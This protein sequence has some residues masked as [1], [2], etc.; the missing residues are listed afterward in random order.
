[1]PNRREGVFD[2]V[3]GSDAFPML[4]RKVIESQEDVALS[5][6]FGDGLVV[7]HT[8]CRDEIVECSVSVDTGFSPPDVVQLSL[9]KLGHRVQHVARFVEPEEQSKQPVAT[10]DQ[11][12]LATILPKE[13]LPFK[14]FAGTTGHGKAWDF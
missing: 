12:P 3:G 2:G 1:M 9:H 7:F 8:I 11:W 6:Q 4:C 13:I 10:R 14:L 5:G